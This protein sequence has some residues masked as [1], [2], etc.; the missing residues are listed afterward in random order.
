MADRAFSSLCRL[1]CA[2]E[3]QHPLL[4]LKLKTHLF[5][6][7]FLFA[8]WFYL[9]HLFVYPPVLLVFISTSCLHSMPNVMTVLPLIATMCI[10]P[11]HLCLLMYPARVHV[12]PI[13]FFVP[14]WVY[15]VHI[16]SFIWSCVWLLLTMYVLWVYALYLYRVLGYLERC[17]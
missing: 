9:P 1:W 3:Q 6:S 12:C 7:A 17:F 8:L 14:V 15:Y 10:Y 13:H 4:K 16:V 2:K 11:L 5:S